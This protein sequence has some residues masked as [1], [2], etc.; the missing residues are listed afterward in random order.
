[1]EHWVQK[2]ILIQFILSNKG[3]KRHSVQI[4]THENIWIEKHNDIAP[5]DMWQN[6]FIR[7]EEK[8]F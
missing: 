3:I 7:D 5:G 6:N 8:D 2:I 4:N 1:M